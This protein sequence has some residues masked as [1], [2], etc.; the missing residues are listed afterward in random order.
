MRTISLALVLAFVLLSGCATMQNWTVDRLVDALGSK[1]AAKSQAAADELVRRGPVVIPQLLEAGFG[2]PEAVDCLVRM[3]R[4]G[5][6]PLV[7]AMLT[8]RDREIHLVAMA[9]LV[10]MGQPARAVLLKKLASKE[11][12]YF[13]EV[14]LLCIKRQGADALPDLAGH[15]TDKRSDPVRELI[16]WYGKDALP[17][18]EPMVQ[19][20]DPAQ[21]KVAAMLVKRIGEP[22]I[23]QAVVL[24]DDPDPNVFREMCDFTRSPFGE[25]SAQLIPVLQKRCQLETDDIGVRQRSQIAA[26]TL[27][28]ITDDSDLIGKSMFEAIKSPPY[29]VDVAT[30]GKKHA[31]GFEDQA[32]KLLEVERD[33]AVYTVGQ[34]SDETIA[35][36]A[37]K[38]AEIFRNQDSDRQY[39]YAAFDVLCKHPETLEAH[40]DMIRSDDFR[41]E[42][43][44]DLDS[45]L[46]DRT[47]PHVLHA[48]ASE[49][50]ALQKKAGELLVTYIQEGSAPARVKLVEGLES[51][52]DTLVMGLLGALKRSPFEAEEMMPPLFNLLQHSNA[53]VRLQAVQTIGSYDTWRTQA[54]EKLK[55]ALPQE[56]DEDVR[57]EIEQ[58][59]NPTEQE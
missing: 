16:A 27:D 40:L 29:F 11:G 45:S 19:S 1:D 17:V 13:R 8:T 23:S 46:R 20:K 22:A 7:D 52:N 26:E 25:S 56:Q 54:E 42:F 59:V 49:D 55:E 48:V 30:Q 21:R 3:G 31:K 44:K 57:Q 10:R 6:K 12:L 51:S 43:P 28:K 47:I 34:M 9:A 33:H 41:R 37:P 38:L 24:M 35:R 15:A 14:I 5:L 39:A 2:R 50:E 58:I 36:V 53:E 32:E 4:P 18:I